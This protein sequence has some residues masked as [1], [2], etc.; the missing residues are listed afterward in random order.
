MTVPKNQTAKKAI[1]SFALTWIF[2]LIFIE[3]F[4]LF[5]L[6][7]VNKIV[8]IENKM[9]NPNNASKSAPKTPLETDDLIKPIDSKAENN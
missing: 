9:D 4:S 7:S 3:I 1:T 5:S 6:W 2:L 8:T